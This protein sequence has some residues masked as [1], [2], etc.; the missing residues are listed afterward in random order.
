[1][2]KEIALPDKM[3]KN[4][5]S[6]M[7]V[8][9]TLEKSIP[10][11]DEH[12]NYIRNVKHI[13]QPN[14]ITRNEINEQK[15]NKNI[16][17]KIKI[18]REKGENIW[19]E[20]LKNIIDANKKLNIIKKT[21]N[22]KV[23]RKNLSYTSKNIKTKK[24][25]EERDIFDCLRI[26]TKKGSKDFSNVTNSINY[27]LDKNK[28]L[29]KNEKKFNIKNFNFIFNP[30]RKS[31]KNR[32]LFKINNFSSRNGMYGKKNNLPLFYEFSLTHRNFYSSKSD[33]SRHE[34][35]LNELHKLKFYLENNP[36]IELLIIKDFLQ[37][38]HIKNIEKYS[39]EKLLYLGKL[40]CKNKENKLMKLIK[41]DSN[42]KNM[43]YNLLDNSFELNQNRN[44]KNNYNLENYNSIDNQF[45]N[46][47]N[48][49]ILKKNKTYYNF[50]VNKRKK[51]FDINETNS[52]LKYIENQKKVDLSN[53]NYSENF[54]LLIN[55]MS[56]EI[57]E[58]EQKIKK[59]LENGSPVK[60]D[61]LFITQVKRKSLSSK[62]INNKKLILSPINIKKRG[63]IVEIP[64]N[65]SIASIVNNK[66]ENFNFCLN[67]KKKKNK[68]V[69]LNAKELFKDKL[70]MK[71]IVQRLYYA[72]TQKKF[73]LSE[74]KRN[75]KLTEYVAFNFAKKKLYWNIIDQVLKSNLEEKNIFYK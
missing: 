19:E 51:Y 14:I 72:Q 71:D 6:N 61:V 41:P 37:K 2:E 10:N 16:F 60:K 27:L 35:L 38:F 5:H 7:K 8:S 67:N 46:N 75:L 49:N 68:I 1:M 58:I 20:K 48:K 29:L 24:V 55:D 9:S 44:P 18:F 25:S 42:I 50:R 28:M 69:Y 12:L 34:F 64:R 52:K 56:K 22:K 40:I 43:I 26:N 65:K 30:N 21:S 32:N 70:Q 73:G 62:N 36:N 23:I 45:S 17:K 74:I 11:R 57:K 31:G 59:E 4:L 15:N 13:L 54:N 33:K 66:S 3:S 47:E 63:K 39:E 53:K